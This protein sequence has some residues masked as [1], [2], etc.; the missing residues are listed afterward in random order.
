MTVIAGCSSEKAAAPAPA[1]ST[2]PSPP[3]PAESAKLRAALLPVPKG[4]KVAYGPEVGTYGELKSTK[5]GLEA[6]RQA[7]LEHPECAGAAQL[8]AARPEIAKAPAAVIG[9]TSDRGAITQAVVALP[10]ADFPGPLP[11]QCDTYRAQV[12]GTEV[13]Y[14]TRDL[15]M[16]RQGDESRAYLT[17]ASGGDRQ[18]QIGTVTIRRGGLVMSLM[19]VGREVKRTGLLELGRLADQNLSRAAV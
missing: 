13:T 1:A 19:V 5:Q 9:F 15:A 12:R 14:H 7:K 16:P 6:I 10:A 8:D 17:T 18:A 4:M 11:G 2:P 3:S